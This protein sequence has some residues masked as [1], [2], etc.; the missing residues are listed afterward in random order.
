M[1]TFICWRLSNKLIYISLHNYEPINK[2]GVYK[3]LESV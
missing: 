1:S 2:I 3:S